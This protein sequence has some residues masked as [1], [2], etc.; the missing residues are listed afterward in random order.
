MSKE[1]YV[2]VN[3]IFKTYIDGHITYKSILD[4]K[5]DSFYYEDYLRI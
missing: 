1:T 3:I 4:N 2:F 5:R